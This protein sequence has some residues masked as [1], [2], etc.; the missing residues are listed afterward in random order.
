MYGKRLAL[1]AA[2][3]ALVVGV[4]GALSNSSG[5]SAQPQAPGLSY[6]GHKGPRHAVVATAP[7][8]GRYSRARTPVG[9]SSAA[10]HERSKRLLQ[11]PL[12][13]LVV[14]EPN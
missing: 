8:E 5:Q 11:R 4:T 7:V 13:G 2:V 6:G 9:D 1:G 3:V 14:P 12:R 10:V